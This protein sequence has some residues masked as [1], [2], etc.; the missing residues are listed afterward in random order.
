MTSHNN[1]TLLH[2]L[3]NT[4]KIRVKELPSELPRQ[5]QDVYQ[6]EVILCLQQSKD[7]GISFP[8]LDATA[9]NPK[10][11]AANAFRQFAEDDQGKHL[12]LTQPWLPKNRKQYQRSSVIFVAVIYRDAM[13]PDS[14]RRTITQLNTYSLVYQ[15]SSLEITGIYET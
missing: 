15:G 13:P 7:T 9:L 11:A 2:S 1:S 5:I 3:Q 14:D 8:H 6:F 4:A 12:L 10:G